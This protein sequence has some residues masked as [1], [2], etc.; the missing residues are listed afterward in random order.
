ML[1]AGHHKTKA[2]VTHGVMNSVFEAIY[3]G[4]PTV[5]LPLMADGADN[6]KRLESKGMAVVVNIMQASADDL[7]HAIANVSTNP[8]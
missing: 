2:F 8:M 5:V 4:I 1:V 6:G 3:H 7:F